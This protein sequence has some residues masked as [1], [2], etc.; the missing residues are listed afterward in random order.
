[1]PKDKQHDNQAE[2]ADM[3]RKIEAIK[4]QLGI[5]HIPASTPGA[6]DQELW[7]TDTGDPETGLPTFRL[8]KGRKPRGGNFA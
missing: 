3:I 4:L 6:S 5:T 8:A 7:P 2:D 1:M